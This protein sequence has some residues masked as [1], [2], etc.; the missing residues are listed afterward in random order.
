MQ[1]ICSRKA[2]TLRFLLEA[3]DKKGEVVGEAKHGDAVNPAT[4]TV[5]LKPGE[6]IKDS[7]EDAAG[8][9]RQVYVEGVG[10]QDL[11]HIRESRIRNGL[12]GLGQ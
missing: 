9:G 2:P 8:L 7:G 5:T 1:L 10:S 11:H 3:Q 6:Q 4:G 12:H